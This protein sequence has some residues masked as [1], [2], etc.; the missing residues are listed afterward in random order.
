LPEYPSRDQLNA[1]MKPFFILQ[2]SYRQA[3]AMKP[4][5]DAS[6]ESKLSIISL[7]EEEA[8][9]IRKYQ[10]HWSKKYSDLLNELIA[11][12]RER[13]RLQHV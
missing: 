7:P 8:D 2:Q 13:D 6:I 12:I 3:W 4:K 5:I 9:R 10:H 11:L 1:W